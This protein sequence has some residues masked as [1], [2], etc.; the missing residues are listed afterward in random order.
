MCH[1]THAPCR[2]AGQAVVNRPVRSAGRRPGHL[3]CHGWNP[4]GRGPPTL[5]IDGNRWTRERS[6]ERGDDRHGRGG[7][8]GARRRPHPPS[9]P[10]RD[11]RP[12]AGDVPGRPGPDRGL[13]RPAH[14]RRR[15]ARRLPP[16]LGGHRLPAGL[17]GVDP[18]VGEVRRH[19][20]PEVLLPGGHRPLPDRV[21]PLRAQPLDDRADRLPGRAGPGRRRPDDR[22]PDHRRRRGVAPRA[23]PL[24]GLLHGHVRGDLGHRPAHRRG[25]RRLPEL[26]VD[27][28]H[29]HP[30]RGGGPGA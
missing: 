2:I 4:T 9:G 28:L 13:H 17:D 25:V 12:D 7:S 20:R 21:G 15:P 3:R 10:G 11:R 6:W 1:D 23:R 14:H 5:A 22:G 29:Q 26:A 8:P 27:L 18:P 30:H 19:V 24:H 16:Q